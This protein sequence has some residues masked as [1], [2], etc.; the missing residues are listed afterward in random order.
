MFPQLSQLE[1]SKRIY[2]FL[3]VFPF[4][5][6]ETEVRNQNQSGCKA[7]E[8]EV[9][10]QWVKRKRLRC[11][12]IKDPEISE[13]LC[14][15]LRNKIGSRGDRCVVST[16][17]KERTPLQPNRLTRLEIDAQFMLFST[18][19]ESRLKKKKDDYD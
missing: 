15:G 1:I 7:L 5:D 4:A 10:I 17:D 13:R 3:V 19:L 9:F 6:M 2:E 18:L 12:R 11:A 8:P 16:S 14:G